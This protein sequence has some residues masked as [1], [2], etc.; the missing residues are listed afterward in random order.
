MKIEDFDFTLPQHLIATFPVRRRDRSRLFVLREDGR[1]EHCYFRDIV[2]YLRE[3]DL[4]ILN[5]SKVIPARLRGR[6]PTGGKLEILLV[7]PLGGG[8][9]E[10]LSRGRYSGELILEGG[11]KATVSEGRIVSFDR[12]DIS[13]Y[14]WKYGL[15]PLP[16]YIKREPLPEDRNWYQTVYAEREGSI[17][18]P[19]AGLHFSTEL[20][21]EIEKRGVK[22]RYITLHVGIGTFMPVKSERVEDHRMQSESFQLQSSLI[23]EIREAK[24]R[25]NR[26]FAVG[27]TVTRTVEAVLS[28]H[29]VNNSSNGL[30]QGSTDLFI[31]PGYEFKAVDV[32]CTNFHLPR[33]TPLLLVA[34]FSGRQRILNAY[35]EAISKNYRFFS[36]GDAMLIFRKGEG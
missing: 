25:G 36:Y 33:S 17:A 35:A 31:Y 2:H 24:A 28:G 21:E 20:L 6:K 30:I 27:T 19:T 13:D 11:L 14:L 9:F 1:A 16:P 23:D 18:A 26:V 12:E 29:F 8:S 4:L 32:L 7:R 15:M 5:N 3:G 22:I 34:A 10:I